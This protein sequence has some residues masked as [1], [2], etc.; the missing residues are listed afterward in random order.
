VRLKL[1]KWN[2]SHT[3]DDEARKRLHGGGKAQRY[4][5]TQR[6]LC[7]YPQQ[8]LASYSSDNVID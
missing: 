5:H 6:L 8:R 2:R 1:G 4:T 7:E 3:M